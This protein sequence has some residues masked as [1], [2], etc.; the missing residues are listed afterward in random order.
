MT[1][2]CSQSSWPTVY[3][4]GSSKPQF[5]SWQWL[6]CSAERR[7]WGEGGWR[8]LTWWG[9]GGVLLLGDGGWPGAV[10]AHSDTTPG[11]CGQHRPCGCLAVGPGQV[12]MQR[13]AP[14][15]GT[16]WVH[17][18]HFPVPN[19][20]IYPLQC[21]CTRVSDWTSRVQTGWQHS[22]VGLWPGTHTVRL[23]VRICTS[24]VMY[25]YLHCCARSCYV[26]CYSS[27]YL[28]DNYMT[29]HPFMTPP[30]SVCSSAHCCLPLAFPRTFSSSTAEHLL[31][32]SST[33]LPGHS[34]VSPPPGTSIWFSSCSPRSSVRC[35]WGTLWY[36]SP[37]PSPVGRSG[38][39]D[40][41]VS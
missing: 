37:P 4:M 8:E 15:T 27:K 11:W 5:Q 28:I 12:D 24:Y 13:E 7:L 9:A 30:V 21:Y 23:C 34:S 41:Q 22:E 3:T 25:D 19:W 35:L 2:L 20:T 32:I 10:Q 40:Q 14:E 36:R 18:S 39:L 33:S 6:F 38:E 16:H 26:G 31:S 17:S 29:W 1:D